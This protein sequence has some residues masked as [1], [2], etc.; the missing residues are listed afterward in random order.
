MQV[1]KTNI[2]W[3]MILYRGGVSFVFNWPFHNSYYAAGEQF[4]SER[5]NE[6]EECPEQQNA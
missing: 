6:I 2:C 1:L 5:I 4:H 3:L